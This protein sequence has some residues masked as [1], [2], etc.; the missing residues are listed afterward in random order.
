MVLRRKNVST[1]LYI[2]LVLWSVYGAA[3]FPILLDFFRYGFDD[4]TYSHAFL[5]PFICAYLIWDAFRGGFLQVA[6]SKKYFVFAIILALVM[7]LAYIAQLTFVYR[8]LFPPVLMAFTAATFR[9]NIPSLVPAAMLFF[10]VPIWGILSIPL[11]RLST[12]AVAKFMSITNVPTFVDENIVHIPSGSF[13]IAG[14]CSGL[15]YFIVSCAIGVLYCYLNLTTLRTRLSLLLVSVSGAL[16]VN[17]LRIAALILIGHYTEMQSPIINDHN[18]FGWYIY[19]P[20]LAVLFAYG[21]ALHNREQSTAEGRSIIDSPASRSGQ[22]TTD[23]FGPVMVLI[24]VVVVSTASAAL[25]SAHSIQDI[26]PNVDI[27]PS[28]YTP[29]V[30]DPSYVTY[31]PMVLVNKRFIKHHYFFL[32]TSDSNKATYYLNDFLPDSLTLVEEHSNPTLKIF[33][34]RNAS[35][36][37]GIVAYSFQLGTFQTSSKSKYRLLR[38]ANALKLDRSSA[39]YWFYIDCNSRAVCD[40]TLLTIQSEARSLGI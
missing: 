8:I 23:R 38:M 22:P 7:C 5:I 27:S 10:V 20:F 21:H 34:T 1:A 32:G 9:P 29:D 14:G 37:F 40:R 12:Y 4:G 19:I 33:L 24:A 26:E 35:G 15:R 2:M 18:M 17:W 6:F 16:L 13:E 11:Q 31:E 39:F 36:S 28:T 30:V 3:N 25:L